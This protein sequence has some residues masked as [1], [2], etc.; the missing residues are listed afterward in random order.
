MSARFWD[1]NEL[2]VLRKCWSGDIISITSPGLLDELVN[3]L[4]GKFSEPMDDVNAYLEVIVLLSEIVFPKGD[5]DIIEV[6]P[7]DNVVIETALLGKADVIVI[8]DR[9][10]LSMGCYEGIG[11]IQSR[12]L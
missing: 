2:D 5:L 9:H 8:G 6:D 12:E 4:L 7:S 3:V 11:I 1:G 10:L